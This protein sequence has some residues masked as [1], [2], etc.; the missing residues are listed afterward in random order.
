VTIALTSY[1][2]ILIPAS[3]RACQICERSWHN[4]TSCLAATQEVPCCDSRF[5]LCWLVST[6]IS[7]SDK[8]GM[9]LHISYIISESR[10]R[11]KR[12]CSNSNSVYT[13]ITSRESKY[14]CNCE[15]YHLEITSR[16]LKNNYQEMRNYY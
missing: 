9:K 1:L 13:I 2:M 3:H 15:Y 6:K 16:I 4:S 8:I 12:N 10:S 14:F 5:K 11:K 7:Q